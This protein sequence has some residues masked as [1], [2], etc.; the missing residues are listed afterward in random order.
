MTVDL[1]PREVASDASSTWSHRLVAVYR[2]R[3]MT[4]IAALALVVVTMAV[5]APR[6]L[7]FS[8]IQDISCF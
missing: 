4:L 5:L 3:E 2:Q 8:N 6:S 1:M 7:S